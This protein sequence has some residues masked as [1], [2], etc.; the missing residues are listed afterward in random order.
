MELKVIY[1]GAI[2]PDRVNLS[3]DF[4]GGQF[5]IFDIPGFPDDEVVFIPTALNARIPLIGNTTVKHWD[6]TSET[7]TDS[8]LAIPREISESGYSLYCAFLSTSFIPLFRCYVLTSKVSIEDLKS[9]LDEI[10]ALINKTEVD[11]SQEIINQVLPIL[12]DTVVT[13]ITGVPLSPS[14]LLPL[15]GAGR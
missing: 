6:E 7:N 12:L 1:D 9:S 8:L 3:Q 5:L 14:L 13:A 15:I 10:K 4:K 2:Y 11:I